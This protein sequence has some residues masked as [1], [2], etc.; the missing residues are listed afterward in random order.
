MN[1]RSFFAKAGGAAAVVVAGA[2]VGSEPRMADELE[3]NGYQIKWRDWNAP[4]NQN[5]VF[6]MW[7]AKHRSQD[8]EYVST[9]LGQC[10]P[11]RAWEVVDTTLAR[12][13]PRLTIFSTEAEKAAVKKRALDALIAEIS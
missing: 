3:H 6:G 11:S 10:Y 7:L 9:T 4:V 5:V 8:N 13:W 2:H 12:D 1:R